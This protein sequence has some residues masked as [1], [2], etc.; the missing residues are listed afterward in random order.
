V[1]STVPP[2]EPE[3]T[4]RLVALPS[5]VKS[6][7]A[8]TSTVICTCW[9][10]GEADPVTVTVYIPGSVLTDTTTFRVDGA[11]GTLTD[12]LTLVGFRP[13][14][15]PEGEMLTASCVIPVNPF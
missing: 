7:G 10:R 13:T 2:D 1:K 11:E 14:E 3:F 12:R 5:R 9:E 8:P 15:G 4:V 6:A